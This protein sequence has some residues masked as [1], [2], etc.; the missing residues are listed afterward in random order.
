MNL[1][2]HRSIEGNSHHTSTIEGYFMHL[3]IHSIAPLILRGIWRTPLQ[4]API[5]SL[6]NCVE[7]VWDIM[8][9]DTGPL[10]CVL[11]FHGANT[12]QDLLEE[13]VANRVFSIL[14]FQLAY[15]FLF[16]GFLL[17][18]WSFIANQRKIG[19]KHV[20]IMDMGMSCSFHVTSA[21]F[22]C[23]ASCIVSV[24]DMGM[25]CLFCFVSTPC[26]LYLLDLLRRRN[27]VR[28]M[29]MLY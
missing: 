28:R 5:W 7:T 25:S 15:F 26:K 21:I 10:L 13:G 17:R 8:S 18:L 27:V 23:H 29:D 3:C 4:L 20:S 19:R 9:L 24:I 2:V 22:L 11:F 6:A 16:N 12:K 14:L 1:A